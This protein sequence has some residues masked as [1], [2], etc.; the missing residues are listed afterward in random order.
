MSCKCKNIVENFQG[1][2][3][4]LTTTFLDVAQ[5]SADSRFN[6]IIYLNHFGVTP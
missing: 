4:P 2:D 6:D 1:G 5:F 3:I